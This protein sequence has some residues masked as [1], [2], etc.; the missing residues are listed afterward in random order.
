MYR[1]YTLEFRRLS[2]YRL[3]FLNKHNLFLSFFEFVRIV[4][5][6]IIRF[7][8]CLRDHNLSFFT[9]IIVYYGL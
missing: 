9:T 5:P 2:L 7:K 8:E 1:Y 6:N 4:F 3:V